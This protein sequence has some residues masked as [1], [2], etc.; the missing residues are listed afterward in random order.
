MGVPLEWLLVSPYLTLDELTKISKSDEEYIELVRYH[1]FEN[2]GPSLTRRESAALRAMRFSP[3]V[4]LPSTLYCRIWDTPRLTQEITE[5]RFL[6]VRTKVH[7]L[8]HIRDKK[9]T[10]HRDLYEWYMRSIHTGTCVRSQRCPAAVSAVAEVVAG[11]DLTMCRY[12]FK[13]TSWGFNVYRGGRILAHADVETGEVQYVD[14]NVRDLVCDKFVFQ[15]IYAE[16]LVA[17]T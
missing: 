8:I 6:D 13:P 2:Y 16:A 15:T 10:K 5:C 9:S 12:T 17:R 7:L 4:E 3:A 1:I 14:R 11:G